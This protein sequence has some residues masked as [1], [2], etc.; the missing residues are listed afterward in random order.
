MSRKLF[1]YPGLST[2]TREL[3]VSGQKIRKLLGS[4]L[5]H[6]LRLK[7][8]PTRRTL[9]CSPFESYT[10]VSYKI[11]C[12]L[13][14]F[15]EATDKFEELANKSTAPDNDASDGDE[16]SASDDADSCSLSSPRKK[17]RLC[18][19]E[20]KKSSARKPEEEASFSFDS[21]NDDLNDNIKSPSRN[22]GGSPLAMNMNDN[23][24]KNTGVSHAKS[25]RPQFNSSLAWKD[26][27]KNS[28]GS[29]ISPAG[30]Q[31]QKTAKPPV[32]NLFSG[33]SSTSYLTKAE[34]EVFERKVFSKLNRLTAM[35]E[36]GFSN[37]RSQKP[38]Q[39]L[40]CLPASIESCCSLPAT[41]VKTLE[42]LDS[43][44]KTSETKTELATYLSQLGGKT[45]ADF[46]GRVLP[47]I[48]S[49]NLCYY[50]NWSGSA[51]DSEGQEITREFK[52][53]FSNLTHIVDMF[54]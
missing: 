46:L 20:S 42:T 1:Q 38:S 25:S 35:V 40:I 7:L 43:V 41:D 17:K 15:T 5:H 27:S 9:S 34:F 8:P 13:G 31:L 30:D 52:K 33:E 22:L 26:I 23:G 47:K 12:S 45:H 6:W 14:T 54:C 50:T 37:I 19:S 11:L 21:D 16:E 29:G 4:N 3:T 51:V 18:G 36:E 49:D 32:R 10:M 48:I 2:P 24:L 44:L 53:T 39:R 28:N